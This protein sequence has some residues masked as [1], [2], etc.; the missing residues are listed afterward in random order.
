MG[1]RMRSRVSKRL[2]GAVVGLG[3]VGAWSA[4]AA[5]TAGASKL[6]SAYDY[7]DTFTGT[8]DG[9]SNPNRPYVA[10][11]QPAAAYTVEKTFGHPSVNFTSPGQPVGVA[12]FSIASDSQGQVP[13]GAAPVYPGSSGA[14]SAT[15]F[16]QTGG[17][18]DYG[19]P[20][21]F[22]TK[23]VVQMD[24]VAS[25]DRI[26]ITTSPAPGGIGQANSISVFFRGLTG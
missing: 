24:A 15:G 23:Y 16:T 4:G 21:G 17:N 20:Y 7:Q 11:I 9:G 10:A 1:E 18:V 14:G 12:A 13:G 26:D 25:S 6:I 5:V 22:R 3:V 19:L 8:T 2:L